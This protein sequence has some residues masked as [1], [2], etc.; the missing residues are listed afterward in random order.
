MFKKLYFPVLIII[1]YGSVAAQTLSQFE[2]AGLVDLL[3]DKTGKYHA[4][5]QEN[6]DNGK[7]TFIYYTSSANKGVSW[8]KPVNL[9]NDN[10]GNGAG[11]PRIVQDV[12]GNIY[13]IWKR[14]GNKN[15]NYPEPSVIL[16]GAG[17]Y[18][19]G[20]L[21]YKVLHGGGWSQAIQLNELEQAQ[22]SWFAT[23]TPR[24][25][26]MVFWTQLSPESVKNNWKT[27]Y[28]ADYL[29]VAALNG[30]SHSAFTDLN[31]PSA[32]AYAGG[33]PPKEGAINLN[34]FVDNN[35]LPH[36]VYEEVHDNM[37]QVKYFNG[38]AVEIIYSYPKYST[39]NTFNY[40]P[41]LLIDDI[42]VEHIIFKPSPSTLESEQ[43]WDYIPSTKKTNIIAAIQKKGVFI[44]S[45]QAYQGP[46][47]EMAVA[48]HAGQYS[49]STECYGTF[50]KKGV[51]KNIGL[52]KNAAKENFFHTEF[53]GLGGYPTSLSTITRYNSQFAKI[54]WD[55][56]GKKAM[57]MNVAA[58][59]TG[60]AYSTS[61]PSIVFSQLD[62]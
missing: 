20:T 17:G 39:N 11:Y 31:K 24:G 51:W 28:Y 16:D 50:Y 22:N 1:C 54:A 62:K 55:A 14:Y 53:I 26:V 6:P 60:G 41:A 27:W 42:G 34:G 9:S 5:F 36:F 23:V 38:K 32:P 59:W 4:V 30:T 3:I 8:T 48:V 2:K 61:S 58:Y 49:A 57:L 46:A 37:Q 13:A 45:F 52:T 35:N 29:R 40:P 15:S 21:F 33:A 18:S 25:E 44:S 10:S 56:Q 19:L 12:A 43:V 7:P 47:G